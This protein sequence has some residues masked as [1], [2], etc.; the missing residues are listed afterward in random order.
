[1]CPRGGVSSADFQSLPLAR[2]PFPPRRRRQS[3]KQ[4]CCALAE[5]AASRPRCN[6]VMATSRSSNSMEPLLSAAGAAGSLYRQC[7]STDRW[8]QGGKAET[9]PRECRQEASRIEDHRGERHRTDSHRADGSG[10]RSRHRRLYRAGLQLPH[11][12]QNL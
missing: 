11:T 1:M 2:S 8:R 12:Q 5:A 3:A 6:S 4:L 7:S 9:R 10:P